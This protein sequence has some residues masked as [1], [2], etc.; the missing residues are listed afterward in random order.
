MF[1]LVS[2]Y[3]VMIPLVGYLKDH[4]EWIAMWFFAFVLSLVMIWPDWF[5]STQ[6]AVLAFPDDG[7][8]MIGPVSGYMAG[9]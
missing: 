9:L 6:L 2:I 7:F 8:F 3:N 4:R 5:L 1:T